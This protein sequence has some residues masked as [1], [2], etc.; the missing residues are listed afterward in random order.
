M[1]ENR[2]RKIDRW[3]EKERERCEREREM[4]YLNIVCQEDE[5]D[6]RKTFLP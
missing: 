3:R 5:R 1:R 4:F 6:E 2:E